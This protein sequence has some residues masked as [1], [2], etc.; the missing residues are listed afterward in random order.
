MK[1]IGYNNDIKD[2]EIRILGSG[3][4]DTVHR[5]GWKGMVVIAIFLLAVVLIFLNRRTNDI[6]DTP[7][8]DVK[9][10]YEQQDILERD[11]SDKAY[12]DI[13]E[14]TL[15]GVPMLIYTPINAK[16]MLALG[17]QDMSDPDIV[18]IAMAADVR[19]D[20]KEI[21]G[22]FV[23]NGEKLAYG[24]SKWG[25][26][27]IIDSKISLGCDKEPEALNEAIAKGGSF[28]RQYGLVANGKYVKDSNSKKYESVRR[29]ICNRGD[30]VFIIESLQP[31]SLL[32]FAYALE[33]FKVDNAVTLVGSTSYGFAV[34]ENGEK[35]EFGEIN[36]EWVLSSSS[37]LIWR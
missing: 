20:N 15:S 28:F 33:E 35:I 36:P 12:V 21:L 34:K 27:A 18:F 32:L 19:A 3:S 29:A 22:D 14:I 17:P 26:C 25:W 2:D 5:F 37:Y 23:L 8:E 16:P 9:G 13:E 30:E 11:E 31:M 4:G 10:L 6:P 7:A 1:R 24:H